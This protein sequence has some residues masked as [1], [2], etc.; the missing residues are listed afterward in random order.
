VAD[1]LAD[2]LAFLSEA[3]LANASK[4]VVYSRGAASVTLQAIIGS[5][6]LRLTDGQG[7]SFI[8]RTDRYYLFAPGDLVLN[9]VTTTPQRGDRIA[10]TT[11]GAATVYEVM[12]PDGEPPWRYS[13]PHRNLYRVHAKRVS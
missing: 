10:E 8:E 1:M 11:A 5:S 4:S 3:L 2:G 6:L 13:D 7:G 9:S 12:P